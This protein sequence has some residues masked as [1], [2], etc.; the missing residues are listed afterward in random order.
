M[1]FLKDNEDTV[2]YILRSSSV[3]RSTDNIGSCDLTL[4]A[5]SSIKQVSM[6][7]QQKEEAIAHSRCGLWLMAENSLGD[8]LRVV[9]FRRWWVEASRALPTSRRRMINDHAV[10]NEMLCVL[11]FGIPGFIVRLF[12][13]V[14]TI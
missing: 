5:R 11:A 10:L 12:G 3:V 4:D 6:S 7:I 13:G 14:P 2:I 1:A 8:S 9:T